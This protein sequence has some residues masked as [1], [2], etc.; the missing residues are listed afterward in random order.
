MPFMFQAQHISSHHEPFMYQGLPIHIVIMS[1]SYQPFQYNLMQ[2][3]CQP[4]IHNSQL[5]FLYHTHT[6]QAFSTDTQNQANI[7][8]TK[9]KRTSHITLSRL[10]PRLGWRVSLRRA[11]PSPSREHKNKGMSNAGSRLSEIPLAWASCLLAQKLSESPGRPFVQ[12][13]RRAPCFISPRRDG[14]AWAR[15]TGLAT[16]LHCNSH[17][18]EPNQHTKHSHTPIRR[19]KS[20]K[21]KSTPLQTKTTGKQEF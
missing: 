1:L 5:V 11:S 7:I 13:L 15:L 9:P 21:Q 17:E 20:Y 8:H 6:Y 10:A 16:V 19:I 3:S 2:N 14:L 18:N 4:F 12:K